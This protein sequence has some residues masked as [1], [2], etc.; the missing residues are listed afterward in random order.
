MNW[1]VDDINVTRTVV[2]ASKS[3]EYCERTEVTIPRSLLSFVNDVFA[4]V[5]YCVDA[6]EHSEIAIY[7]HFESCVVNGE[8]VLK[9]GEAL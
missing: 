3:A 5:A 8:I 6:D 2:D 1:M 7:V 9:T 4:F